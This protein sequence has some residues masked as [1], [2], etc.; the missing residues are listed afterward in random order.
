MLHITIG[1]VPISQVILDCLVC[2]SVPSPSFFYHLS[3]MFCL[4]S[5]F[6]L[7]GSPFLILC[8]SVFVAVTPTVL[9]LGWNNKPRHRFLLCTCFISLVTT[10]SS[11]A[12]VLRGIGQNWWNGQL[13]NSSTTYQLMLTYFLLCNFSGSCD[14]ATNESHAF[15]W[16]WGHHTFIK[17]YCIF[18]HSLTV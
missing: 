16:S 14:Q 5:S 17:S 11:P 4:L 12:T 7:F 2:R 10:A 8:Y 13:I 18:Q 3:L 15:I 6:F 9:V 1:Y